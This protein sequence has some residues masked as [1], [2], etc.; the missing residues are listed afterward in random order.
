[1]DGA[2]VYNTNN[3]NAP[4]N[5][6]M[7]SCYIHDL[8]WF[9][10]D[11]SH[12]NNQT[13]NDDV[14]IEGGSNI[15]MTGNNFTGLI[16]TTVGT[17]GSSLRPPGNQA[18]SAF[19]IKPDVGQISDIH[20]LHNWLAGGQFT[21]NIANDTDTD[22]TVMLGNIGEISNNK[23]GRN[24]GVQGPGGDS[25]YTISMPSNVTCTTVGNVYEDNGDPILVR[26]NG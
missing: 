18:N 24:Q 14:Q 3:V 1:V 5:F 15:H 10:P 26:H 8:A 19:M 2:D 21:V 16:S 23:F 17:L 13:H 6:T 7:E 9:T 25:T 11:P 20:I 22:H 4:V 12:S